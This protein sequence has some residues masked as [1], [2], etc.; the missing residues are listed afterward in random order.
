MIREIL[1]T[2]LVNGVSG[3]DVS[4]QNGQDVGS[5]EDLALDLSSLLHVELLQ[6]VEHLL[7]DG[8]DL[9]DWL[10]VLLII[11]EVLQVV[12]EDFPNNLL[13]NH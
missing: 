13:P 4:E 5:V 8:A 3:R 12:R 11:L 1:K 10:H 7:D 6:D 9:H 2:E